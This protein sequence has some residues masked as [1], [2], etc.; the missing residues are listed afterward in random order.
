VLALT[1]DSQVIDVEAFDSEN[2]DSQKT[3]SYLS[4]G[5]G[6]PTTGSKKCPSSELEEKSEHSLDDDESEQEHNPQM[7]KNVGDSPL[8]G[9]ES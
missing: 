3:I 5:G 4:K 6:A 8:S 9:I 2:P 7:K 1:R